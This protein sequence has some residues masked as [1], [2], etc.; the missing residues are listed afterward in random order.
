MIRATLIAALL[1]TL[2]G[3]GGTP[4]PPR[5]SY[6]VKV[7]KVHPQRFGV[8]V[9]CE[10]VDDGSRVTFKVERDPYPA[11]G[12]TWVVDPDKPDQTWP[13]VFVERIK[14]EPKK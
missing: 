9:V 10:R 8:Q 5:P 6:A 13:N 7:L 14:T 3:C 2:L 12:E 1:A 11:E 4:R